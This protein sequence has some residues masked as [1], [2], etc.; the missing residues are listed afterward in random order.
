MVNILVIFA[1]NY[2][3][4]MENKESITHVLENMDKNT[5]YKQKSSF[6]WS[7]SLIVLGVVSFIIYTSF[8]WKTSD[9]LPHFL[10]ILGSVFLIIGVLMFFFRKEHYYSA[11]SGQKLK[12]TQIYFQPG[13]QNK[14]VNLMVESRIDEVKNL[15]TSVSD[16]L[17]LSVMATPDGNIC[18]SQ[19]IA[20]VGSEYVNITDVKTHSEAEAVML[21]SIKSK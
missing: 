12:L 7:L 9:A 1:L 6:V 16:G 15:K 17:K 2:Y 4:L 20:Y 18:L 10:F 13:E 14:L 11:V 3:I 21:I 8:D 19:V 5:V